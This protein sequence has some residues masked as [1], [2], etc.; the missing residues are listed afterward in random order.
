MKHGA[1]LRRQHR[2][3]LE[4]LW[5]LDAGQKGK[6]HVHPRTAEKVI[7]REDIIPMDDGLFPNSDPQSWVH[8]FRTPPRR[9]A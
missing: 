5:W 9:L 8:R 1:I 2:Q 3:D 6:P 7:R 4:D